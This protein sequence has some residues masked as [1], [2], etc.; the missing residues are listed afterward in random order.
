MDGTWAAVPTAQVLTQLADP[1]SLP[2]V[3]AYRCA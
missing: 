3:V 2:C 1:M